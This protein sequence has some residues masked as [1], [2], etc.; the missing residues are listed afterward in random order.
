MTNVV[1]K[2]KPQGF[3]LIDE[4]VQTLHITNVKGLP[5]DNVTVVTMDMLNAEGLG[6][7]GKYPQKYDL[8]SQGGYAAFYFLVLNGF[9]IDLNEGDQFDIDHLEDTYVEV[10]IVHKDG[11]NPRDDGTFPVFANIKSTIGK[12]V[13]FDGAVKAAP[14]EE[15]ED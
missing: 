7:N 1:G 9:G 6:F 10:E 5:R 2:G 11:T 12:G 4:G 15:W 13:P 14:A 8:A 3:K